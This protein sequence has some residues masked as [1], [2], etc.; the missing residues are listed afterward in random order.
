MKKILL[1]I[2]MFIAM[3]LQAQVVST[4]EYQIATP[5]LGFGYNQWPFLRDSSGLINIPWTDTAWATTQDRILAIKP[6]MVRLLLDRSWFNSTDDQVPLPIGTY[7]WN[8][9]LMKEV[10]KSMDFYKQQGIKVMCGLWHSGYGQNDTDQTFLQSSGTG[11]FAQLQADLI[12]YLIRVKG[13]TNMV[14][15]APLNEPAGYVPSY[16]TYD[17]MLK[18]LYNEL[19]SRNLPD[20]ILT[21]ADSWGDWVWLPAQK[22][23]N[24]LSAYD[25]HLYLNDT[26]LD[27]YNWLYNETLESYL[28]ASLMSIASYD[29]SN[30]PFIMSELAPV[31]VLYCDWYQNAIQA[32]AYCQNETYEYGLGYLDYAIQLTRSGVS[33]GLAWALDGFDQNKDAGMWN[34]SGQHGGFL[35]RPWYYVWQWMCRNFPSGSTIL[36]MSEPN[37]DLRIAGALIDNTDFSFAVINRNAGA[38]NGTQT[39][40]LKAP[41]GQKTFY[42]YYYSNTSKGDGS[43]LTL[44]YTT[45]T[46]NNLST[47]GITV[48]IPPET[49]VFLT[50]L[51]PYLP[52]SSIDS[53]QETTEIEPAIKV[54]PNPASDQIFVQFTKPESAQ[55]ELYR[56]DGQ[57]INTLQITQLY[58]AINVQQLNIQGVVIV[59]VITA[60]H[61]YTTKIIVR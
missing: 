2:E 54:Y 53:Q 43:S 10:Y 40:T 44:P 18:N 50:T 61:V 4:V 57:L 38:V 23:K 58:N 41:A 59:K 42:V 35:L 12:D 48:T 56:L 47:D 16:T 34:N 15:Y 3:S 46:T 20:T 52:T 31:G 25:A 24:L 30:K 55:V 1:L 27:T 36:H 9:K 37:K 8:G 5:W 32:P 60:D 11:S 7:N 28:S 22:D 14:F 17:V 13:Y 51:L 39:L 33:G 26:P 6:S 45:M 21:A 19:K 49:G 29:N